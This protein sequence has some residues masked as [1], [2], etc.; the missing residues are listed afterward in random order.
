[1]LLAVILLVLLIGSALLDRITF[2]QM[3]WEFWRG[4]VQSPTIII[5]IVIVGPI[6]NG[7]WNRAVNTLLPLMKENKLKE[8]LIADLTKNDRWRESTAALVAI[9]A[10][11]VISIY[12]FNTSPTA[13]VPYISGNRLFHQSDLWSAIRL[14]GRF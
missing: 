12:S 8:K 3:D 6:I 7:Y 11:V 9:G 2:G 13:S 4:S 14:T 10:I 5:Y 1:V